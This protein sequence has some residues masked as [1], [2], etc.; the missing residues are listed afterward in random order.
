MELNEAQ[1]QQII[2]TYENIDTDHPVM[3]AILKGIVVVGGA[4]LFGW[5]LYRAE[6]AHRR[7]D[8]TDAAVSKGL[9]E[10]EDM[11]EKLSQVSETYTAQAKKADEK[12]EK[13]IVNT[14]MSVDEKL[15]EIA[16]GVKDLTAAARMFGAI[17][18]PSSS[19]DD[20]GDGGKTTSSDTTTQSSGTDTTTQQE[21]PKAPG[22]KK[23][24]GSRE[25]QQAQG[26]ETEPP[27]ADP[28]L[29]SQAAAETRA[30]A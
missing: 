7:I 25:R 13:I 23:S 8:E 9:R 10:I 27:K 30:A 19:D 29:A 15:G 2:E 1:K 22:R 14:R 3:D 4:A 28:N 18:S 5:T 6:S 12:L 11:S 24:N 17:I 20:G 21:E 16:G 26:S